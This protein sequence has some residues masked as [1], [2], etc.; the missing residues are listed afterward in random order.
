MSSPDVLVLGA[1][2]IGAACAY[3]LAGA[4]A[5]VAVLERGTGW[6]EGCSSGNAGLVVPSHAR[7]IAAPESLRAGLGWMLRR[8]SPFGLRLR[9]SLTP[10]LIRYLRAATERRAAAGE[11][12]QRELSREG[13]A[14]LRELQGQ[15][16]DSG[17]E[18][19]GLLSAH[20]SRDAEAHAAEEAGSET[21]RA[22][23]AKVLSAAEAREIEP[24]LT[25]AV[26][27]GVLFPEEGRLDPERL[28][29]SLGAAAEQRGAELRRG[30]E[31]YRVV[32]QPNGVTVETSS[33]PLHAGH[34]VLAA[35][36]WSE[37]LAASLPVRLPLQG[38]KGYMVEYEP[39]AAPVRIPLYLHDQRVVAN[40]LPDRTRFT[41][42]LVLDGLD[43]RFEPGR[44]ESIR[45]AA[46]VVVGVSAPVRRAWRGLRPCTPD[47]LPVIGVHRRAARVV[48]ATG[49]GMLGVTLGPL[50]GT[51][52]ADLV[53]GRAE[54]QALPALSPERFD[55]RRSA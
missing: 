12:L 42:G 37:R 5:S 27:A 20:T 52:V 17:F 40:P 9:P 18:Q 55:L 23:G 33:G 26:R 28:V 31:A 7:P 43:E 10:W 25:A 44:V 14:R 47:G 36:A 19:P 53:A 1:G 13:L 30:I 6:G 49:H 8:D 54:H 38:G 16:V 29:A 51:L 50:T 45:R 34:V 2:V 32:P 35:G 15:G 39:A 46:D 22:L 4:G 48:F 3:E 41:G 24:S 21:G 11:R